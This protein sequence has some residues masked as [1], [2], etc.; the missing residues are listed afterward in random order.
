MPRIASRQGRRRTADVSTEEAVTFRD[1]ML[2]EPV[3]RGLHDSGFERPSPIQLQAIPV[4]QFGT[5]LIAQAKS[6][7]GKTCVFSVI[8]LEAVRA[9][10]AQPQAVVLA[11]TREIAVQIS[12]VI[13][14]IGAHCEG[15]RA[16][17]FIGGIAITRDRER[18]RSCN[19][20]VGTPGRVCALL[21]EGSLAVEAIRMLVLDEA[22]K[23]LDEIF[24]A[25][26]EYIVEALPPRKQVLAFSATYTAEQRE[27]L[28]GWMRQPNL[29][30]LDADRVSLRG[31]MQRYE[32]VPVP[33]SEGS[34]GRYA[35]YEGKAKVLLRVLDRTSFHQCQVFMNSRSRANDLVATLI[36]HGYP[37]AF[38]SADLSQH[39]RNAVMSSMRALRLRVLV[40]T[41]LTARGVDV[42][43]VNLVVNVDLPKCAE[44]YIHRVG[45]TGRFGTHGLAIALVGREE[46]PVLLGMVKSL[47]TVIEPLTGVPAAADDPAG[48]ASES[49]SGADGPG[50]DGAAGE[51][52]SEEGAGTEEAAAA[53]QLERLR[54]LREQA[55]GKVSST[56]ELRRHGKSS[57]E[58]G[59]DDGRSPKKWSKK[60]DFT[61]CGLRV[62][63]SDGS[64]IVGDEVP[65]LIALFQR[66]G[67]IR[68]TQ[69]R[70]GKYHGWYTRNPP[71][72]Q[73]CCLALSSARCL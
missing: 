12:D 58:D 73:R 54:K 6:G 37:A 27:T 64:A 42:E 47:N 23:L 28:R 36:H 3:L 26:I 34:S 14:A 48:T 10:R 33:Q 32:L 21:S 29:V 50:G 16:E 67:E 24:L 59:A 25:D 68:S 7:T 69:F 20:V 49:R 19:V 11:P 4:G 9:A 22:D 71:S 15:L 13:S 62:S 60:R 43:R 56:S 8:V 63:F 46:L 57:R 17:V 65:S 55:A 38:I 18:A 1:M 2:S 41:D 39:Q 70:A 72:R 30:L 40:S 31:V 45:R 53:A 52:H 44:T 61:S 51:G 66:Y 35:L 5:D